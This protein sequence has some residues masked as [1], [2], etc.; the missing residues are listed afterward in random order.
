MTV[1]R[2]AI[3]GAG[4]IAGAY[5]DVVGGIDD[6]EVVAVADIRHR[7]AAELATRMGCLARQRPGD[8]LELDPDAVVLCTPPNT[9]PALALL[10]LERGVAVLSEKPLAIGRHAASAMA[11]AAERA[12]VPLTMATKFRFCDDVRLARA[13][14]DDGEIGGLRLVENAFTADT[15]MTTRWNSDPA[16]SGGGVI[17][18]NGTH[19]VDLVHFLAGP[20]AEVF[21]VEHRRPEGMAVEDA[22]TLHLRTEDGTDATVD[23]SW[24]LDKS[25]P[26]F[27]RLY[28]TKGEVRVGWR[29][30]AWRR[31][32]EDW[33]TLGPGYAKVP[34]M[35]G[36][37]AQFC[38]ALRGEEALETT[39]AHGVV[40]A[41]VVDACYESMRTGGWVKVADLDP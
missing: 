24:S 9:H 39:A 18:D 40:A 11:D 5:A 2:L 12:G 28:G 32:G 29:G 14:L 3:V 4:A 19:S 7:A 22:A 36:A 16:V 13:L 34:A 30:S 35:R 6:L 20:V 31:N 41:Q 25:L 27:L 23:L 1:T 15:D 21:A 37:L 17:I 38:R 10:F 33:R 8:L 26:V